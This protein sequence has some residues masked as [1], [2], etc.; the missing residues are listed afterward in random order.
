MRRCLVILLLVWLPFQSVWAEAAAYCRHESVPA[1]VSAH[2]GHHEHQHAEGGHADVA[3][4]SN[5]LGGA[6][7]DCNACH[8]G[9]AVPFPAWLQ[10]PAMDWAA[11]ALP[12]TVPALPTRALTPPDKPN[13]AAAA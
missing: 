4:A 2:W 3:G 1:G 8:A 6:D 13:W 11:T 5:S 10:N 7:V 9:G 12:R